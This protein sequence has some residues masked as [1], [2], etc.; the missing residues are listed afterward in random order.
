MSV[1]LRDVGGVASDGEYDECWVPCAKGDPGAVEFNPISED[2]IADARSDHEERGR[3][4]DA[5]CWAL[6]MAS[7][8]FAERQEG[9]GAYWWRTELRRRAWPDGFPY[10]AQYWKD[11]QAGVE[12]PEWAR[13]T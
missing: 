1:Y 3:F 5:L 8:G 13:D 2:D 4:F 11:R 9:Q 10:A 12:E 6:G 7:E